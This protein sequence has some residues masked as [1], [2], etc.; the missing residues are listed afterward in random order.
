MKDTTLGKGLVTNIALSFTGGIFATRFSVYCIQIGASA[1]SNTYNIEEYI[2]MH[3]NFNLH[4]FI[5]QCL[6]VVLRVP[7]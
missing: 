7:P 5:F 3:T 6:I 1:L 2:A 4:G